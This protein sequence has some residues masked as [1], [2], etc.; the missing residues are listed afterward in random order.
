MFSKRL[1]EFL[2][3]IFLLIIL[4]IVLNIFVNYLRDFGFDMI[5]IYVMLLLLS[6]LL[7]YYQNI[8]FIVF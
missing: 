5:T 3:W 6:F 8:I 2:F 7:Y 4:N 1:K